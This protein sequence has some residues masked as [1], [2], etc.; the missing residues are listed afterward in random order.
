MEFTEEEEVPE[1]VRKYIDALN[2]EG[3]ADFIGISREYKKAQDEYHTVIH[4]SRANQ[5]K[6]HNIHTGDKRKT[7]ANPYLT[8]LEDKYKNKALEIAKKHGYI[9]PETIKPEVKTQP[10]TK[11]ANAPEPSPGAPQEPTAQMSDRESKI[12]AFK[13]AQQQMA[14]AGKQRGNEIERD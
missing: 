5:V 3:Y 11:Q 12:A 9:E 10:Q 1:F 6:K 7:D 8:E 4:P 2:Y 13:A 14:E